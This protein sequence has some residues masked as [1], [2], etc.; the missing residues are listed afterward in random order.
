[1]RNLLM[2]LV[3]LFPFAT[4]AQEREQPLS[5]KR[6]TLLQ[7]CCVLPE[8]RTEKSVLGELK[9]EDWKK[10]LT[11]KRRLQLYAVDPDKPENGRLDVGKHGKVMG[12]W[13]QGK[14]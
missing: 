3:L 4:F 11:K 2:Y 12:F 10:E 13:Y 14:F 6:E 7:N 9:Q 5:L 1:M 8:K